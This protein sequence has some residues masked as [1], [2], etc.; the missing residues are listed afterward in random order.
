M[1]LF[2]FDLERYISSVRLAHDL[3]MTLCSGITRGSAQGLYVVLDL[4]LDKHL[5]P[6]TVSLVP[7]R[8]QFFRKFLLDATHK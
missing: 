8:L 3:L 2:I 6:W 7:Q 1:Y 4:N 5:N